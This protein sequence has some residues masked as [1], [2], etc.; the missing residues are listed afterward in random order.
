[1]FTYIVSLCKYSCKLVCQ[2]LRE[3]PQRKDL[4]NFHDNINGVSTVSCVTFVSTIA[5]LCQMLAFRY[6]QAKELRIRPSLIRIA[7]KIVWILRRR[8][9][10]EPV[11]PGKNAH[12]LFLHPQDEDRCDLP[13][14]PPETSW[15][16]AGHSR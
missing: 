8:G 13:R 9:T 16:P 12:R 6:K 11:L 10:A 14:I 7:D 2:F 3:V 5:C 4:L 1:M 15:F